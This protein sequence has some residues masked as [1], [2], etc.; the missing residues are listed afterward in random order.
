[1]AGG[2]ADACEMGAADRA[3]LAGALEAWPVTRAEVLALSPAPM[4]EVTVYDTRCAYVSRDGETANLVATPHQAAG[5]VIGGRTLP[6]GPYAAADADN[7]FT[8][9]LPSVWRHAG[10]ESNVGLERFVT[11]VFLH[12]VMH[13]TQS[14]LL[15][16]ARDR[17]GPNADGLGALSD[18]TIQEVFAKDEGYIALY[19]FELE[20]LYRAAHAPSDDEARRLAREALAAMDQRRARF[21]T[22]RRA[23]LARLD[24]TFLTM[25]GLGQMVMYRYLMAQPGARENP[26]LV[27]G[28]VRNNGAYW[29]QDAGF[30]LMRVVERLVPDWQARVFDPDRWQARKLLAAAAG[31]PA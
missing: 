30:G 21:F 27:L 5:I 7:R 22:G 11:G 12:E 19:R 15:A 9:S 31:V 23:Y 28:E 2:A 26:A 24:D 17:I 18:D 14:R 13:T 20:L 29:S 3:W 1:M 4:P 16:H 10:V 25:E 8:M 6:A